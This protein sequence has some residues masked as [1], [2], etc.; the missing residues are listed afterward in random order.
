MISA[1]NVIL[2]IILLIV[3]LAVQYFIIAMGTKKAIDNSIKELLEEILK[4]MKDK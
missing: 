2:W 1:A 4:E 3:S